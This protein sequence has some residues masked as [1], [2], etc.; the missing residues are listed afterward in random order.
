MFLR[1]TLL[2]HS[3]SSKTTSTLST[4]DT[5]EGMKTIYSTVKEYLR[6][7]TWNSLKERELR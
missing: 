5:E 2:S 3:K 1:A 7:N 6:K 4:L